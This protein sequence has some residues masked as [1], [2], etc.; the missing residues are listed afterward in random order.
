M[1]ITYIFREPAAWV[2]PLLVQ[3]L[4]YMKILNKM[5]KNSLYGIIPVLGEMEMS[6]DLFRKMRSFWRP[7]VV[8][9]AMYG[10]VLIIGRNNE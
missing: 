8:T 6:K 9:A 4:S 7:A 3:I 10:T 2:L 1:L 5:G